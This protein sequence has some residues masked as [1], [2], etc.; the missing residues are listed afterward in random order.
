MAK[1]AL[2]EEDISILQANIATRKSIVDAYIAQA[3]KG[4]IDVASVALTAM[5]DTDN[6]VFKRARLQADEAKNESETA[7]NEL[8]CNFLTR[9]GSD[10]PPSQRTAPLPEL[11]SDRSPVFEQGVDEIGVTDNSYDRFISSN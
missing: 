6:S 8:M 7:I 5:A 4:D 11:P 10:I 1:S 3:L 2:T 9:S